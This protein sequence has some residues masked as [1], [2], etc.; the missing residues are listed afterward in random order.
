MAAELAG[1]PY[2]KRWRN[3]QSKTLRKVY[4]EG[5]FS[6]GSMKQVIGYGL[7]VIGKAF[8]L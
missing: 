3:P 5:K 8:Y 1:R 6:K 4:Q 2:C 7:W